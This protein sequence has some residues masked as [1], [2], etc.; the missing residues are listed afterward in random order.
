MIRT[1]LQ[2]LMHVHENQIQ[3]GTG[4]I[5]VRHLCVLAWHQVRQE[6][7]EGKTERKEG[8]IS[9]RKN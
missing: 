3:H 6:K 8:S 2:M 7:N 5:T 1:T 4:V 9:Q